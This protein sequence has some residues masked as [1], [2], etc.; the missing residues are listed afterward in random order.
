M[1]LTGS[2]GLVSPTMA[3]EEHYV[4]VAEP[5][6]VYADHVTPCSG[7]TEKH[8]N[9]KSVME[10]IYAT[11]NSKRESYG[12]LNA[13]LDTQCSGVCACFIATNYHCDIFCSSM[14]Y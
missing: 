7:L 4:M 11:Q 8:S 14:M 1:Q 3:V 9:S 5:G 13:T 6:G 12:I 10:V 2:R